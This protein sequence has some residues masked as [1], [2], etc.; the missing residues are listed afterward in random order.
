MERPLGLIIAGMRLDVQIPGITN[1]SIQNLHIKIHISS[2][3]QLASASDCYSL[4]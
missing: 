3:A 4:Q 1:V 2:V